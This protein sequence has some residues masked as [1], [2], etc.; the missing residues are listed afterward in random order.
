MDKWILVSLDRRVRFVS[1]RPAA[2]LGRS[3]FVVNI[4]AVPVA[5]IFLLTVAV[6]RTLAVKSCTP[7]TCSRPI[8]YEPYRRVS[9]DTF[10]FSL[11]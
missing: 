10:H 3:I 8:A 2:G 7:Q 1:D 4:A 5:A 6:L 9:F 11:I